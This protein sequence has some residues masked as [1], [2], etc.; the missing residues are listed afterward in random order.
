MPSG[1]FTRT[2]C[3][4]PAAARCRRRP[5]RRRGNR[6]RRSRAPWRNPSETPTTMLLMRLRCKPCSDR[7]DRVSSARDTRRGRRL[8]AADGD[9]ADDLVFQLAL[10]TLH[11]HAPRHRHVDAARDCDRLLAD[12]RHGNSA[13]R[14]GTG[15]RRRPCA[16]ASRS[17]SRPWLVDKIAIPMPPIPAARPRPSSTPGGRGRNALQPGDCPA[18]IA[19][20]LHVDGEQ[21]ARGVRDGRPP[22]SR[23]CSPRGRGSAR[24]PPSASRTASRRRRGTWCSRRAHG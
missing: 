19:R 3:E 8:R 23:R 22:R 20:V 13:T 7:F 2:G 15:P 12:A 5:A 4:K 17:V 6:R 14:P 21:P 24:R 18:T 11:R 9:A 1:A 16:R 10:R